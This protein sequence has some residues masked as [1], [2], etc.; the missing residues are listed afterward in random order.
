MIPI[1][2]HDLIL[3]MA[4]SMFV[5][6]LVSIGAGVFLLVTK[7]IG[8]DVK[9]IAR[10]TTQIAQKGLADDIAGLVG[11]ASSL[12]EGLNQL[13]KTTSGIGTF[14]V[15]VGIVIVVASF[16]MALQIL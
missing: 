4:V 11:N 15:V 10:Q 2:V 3:T 6:G 8:E 9:T 13:V 5:I 1:T 14:L 7:I 12:I 16:L